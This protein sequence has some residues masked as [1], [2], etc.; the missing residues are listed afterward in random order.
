MTPNQT[1]NLE[2]GIFELIFPRETLEASLDAVAALGVGWIQF[3]F[4]SAGLPTL[5]ESISPGLITRIREACAARSIQIAAV[6]G[7]YNMIDPDQEARARG[8]AGLKT[9]IAAARDLGAPLVT[10]CTGTRDPES[11]WRAHPDNRT[12]EA[13]AEL[14]AELAPLLAVAAAHGVLLGVEPEPANVAGSAPLAR[15]LLDEMAHPNLKIILDP[16]NAIAADLT[17]SPQTVL[18]EAFALLGPDIASAHAKDLSADGR[19]CTAGTGVVPWDRFITLCREAGYTGPL[20]L[21]TLTEPEAQG[22]VAFLRERIAATDMDRR[23]IQPA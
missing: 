12:P 2:P 1:P 17:R 19:F 22:A 23:T 5:P 6:A 20:I 11:M 14:E 10:L 7:T 3:D 9:V 13:W 21:H 4:S 8:A 18:E 15:S 16:A